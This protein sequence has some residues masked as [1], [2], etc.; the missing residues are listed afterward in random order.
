VSTAEKWIIGLAS[1]T[2]VVS[3]AQLA[4]SEWRAM[5]PRTGTLFLEDFSFSQKESG[6]L[7]REIRV[8]VRNV[9]P[10]AIYN[11]E[12][13]VLSHGELV[14]RSFISPGRV[15]VG[16]RLADRIRL[17]A[18]AG[19]EDGEVWLFWEDAGGSQKRDSDRRV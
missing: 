5:R 18:D 17:P 2:L 12:V 1:A 19:D 3:V 4:V 10:F 11:P 13:R 8:A 9:G 6:Q 15:E 16:Q 7:G 14:A